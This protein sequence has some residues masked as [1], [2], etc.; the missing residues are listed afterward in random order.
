[1]LQQANDALKSGNTKVAINN[2]KAVL[3]GSP[4]NLYALYLMRKIKSKLYSDAEKSLE[5]KNY[6][7]AV[8]K[9]ETFLD[10]DPQHEEGKALHA[11]AKKYVH[12]D[13]AQKAMASDNPMA[14]L[15]LVK[16][17]LRLDPQ[18][19]EA[20]KLQAEAS[21]QVEKKIA[22]LVETAQQ[23]IAEKQYEKLRDLAQDI[24]AIDP[25]NAEAADFL[26]EAQAQILS[27][28]KEENL[29][30]A[31]QFYQE[32][33]YESA[34]AKA[35]EV[36]KVDPTSEEAMELMQKSK[37]ELSK[38]ELRLRSITL[39]GGMQI[40][41]IEVPKTKEKYRVKE[42]DVFHGEGDFKVSAVDFDLKAVV[43][44]YLKTGSMQ[45]ITMASAD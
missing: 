12:F 34:L 45:T 27:R 7:D 16:E 26:R 15:R 40:A 13:E 3:R 38:P 19:E 6:K 17:A 43:V 4:R 8:E 44:T 5:A 42:G 31:R 29:S 10:L 32:G 28:N 30:L 21:E 39:I 18:F 24:L 25:Q 37:A 23:L 11:E 9:I 1:M 35:E 2:T 22:T 41:N 33:I 36:L 20:K 14:A